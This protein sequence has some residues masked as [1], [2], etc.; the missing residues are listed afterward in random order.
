MKAGSDPWRVICWIEQKGLLLRSSD[1]QDELFVTFD[2][3]RLAKLVDHEFVERV[4][5]L[6]SS[7]ELFDA[8]KKIKACRDSND[9]R[10]LKLA[11][12]E[13]DDAIVSD[14]NDLLIVDPFRDIPIMTPAEFMFWSVDS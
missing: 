4:K 5:K 13:R 14:D 9:D 2:K 1:S 7:A 3:P 11:V 6:I 12:N 10:F 8:T